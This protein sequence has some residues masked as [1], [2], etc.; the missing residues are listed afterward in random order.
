MA[1]KRKINRNIYRRGV[2]WWIR[3]SSKGQQVRE[4]SESENWTMLTGC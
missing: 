4:S 2:I 3:Y 1:R